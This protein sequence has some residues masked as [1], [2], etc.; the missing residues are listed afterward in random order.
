MR[1]ITILLLLLSLSFSVGCPSSKQNTG[2]AA[3]RAYVQKDDGTME[4]ATE[5]GGSQGSAA[6]V[7]PKNAGAE[8]LESFELTER[9]G[10]Q[11]S[12]ESLKGQP[13]VVSFFF[14]TC[15]TICKRQNEK[16]SQLQKNFKGKPIRL[17]SITCDPEVDVPE[18]LSIYA[19]GLQAD[20]N[21]WLFL[22]GD[23]NYLSR[24]GAEMFFLAVKRRFHAEKL[25][26]MDA[27]GKIYGGYD[28]N[29]EAQFQQLQ[30]DMEAMIKAG[31]K[32]PKKEV[33]PVNTETDLE[34]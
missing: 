10:K 18:V 33:P 25:L 27:D 32:L 30:T 9:S 34:G 28:W 21:Q 24:V 1:K 15:P 3:G 29:Q 12:S 14:T 23:L 20:P 19:D 2:G 8:W 4:L 6:P 31:G 5:D 16:V 26:L 7:R 11:V 13:Y 22:T 17:V